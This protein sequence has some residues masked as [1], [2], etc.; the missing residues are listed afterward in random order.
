MR[1]PDFPNLL[2][3]LRRQVPSRPTL[4]EFFMNEQVYDHFTAGK[5]F[6]DS[7]GLGVWRKRI[8][9]FAGAGYDYVTLHAADFRF[10]R[11][12]VISARTRSQ[13]QAGIICSR[14]GFQAYAWPDP[15]VFS[16]DRL[17]ILAAD[18][19][20]GMQLIAYGPGGVL[21]NVTD[22]VGFT[23]M[24]LMLAED[25]DLLQEICNAVGSRLLR[26]YERSLEYPAVG[27]VI[28]NDDWGFAQQTMLAPADMRRL[29]FP[30]HRRMVAVAHQAGRPAIL[31]SCGNLREV[32]DDVIDDLRFDGKHSFEDKIQPVEEAYEEYGRRI[33]ILGGFDL[34][35]I[36]QATPA[37]IRRRVS[38]MLERTASRGGFAVGTGN[39]VPDY[40][41][42]ENYLAMLEPV[43][44]EG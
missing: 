12:A 32:M 6:D 37:E 15:D 9:A 35:F 28:V 23:D 3:V 7:D 18:L 42:L 5:T 11:P 4:F 43:L 26:Y 14:E 31:H 8:A 33:A 34:N 38:A 25:P 16:Y 39:S 17:K 20:E 36:C 30:W 24:C 40:V 44:A 19:P 10:A 27:A 1:Q 41:P 2:Q 29:I 21:E 22:L 13:N